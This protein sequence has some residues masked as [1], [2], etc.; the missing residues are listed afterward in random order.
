[1]SKSTQGDQRITLHIN[2]RL[3]PILVGLLALLYVL[4]GFKGWLIFFI[5]T[6]GAWLI[7]WLWIYSL[8]RNLRVERK[9]H[10]AWATVG[11]S[12]PEQLKLTNHGWLPAIWVE[13]TDEAKTL[14]SPLRMVSD[15]GLHSAHTRNLSHLFKRRGFY[16]LGPTHI[17]TADPF[18]IYVLSMYDWHTS[19][20]LVTP[21]VLPLSQL[22]IPS[23]G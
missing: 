20:I 5:G 11:E 22:H 6:G 10:L 18:G 17:R 1:M 16:T 23:A 2:L 7:A 3:L 15:V 4:T 21:P 8:S 19:S 12:V 14:E 13:L 9:I